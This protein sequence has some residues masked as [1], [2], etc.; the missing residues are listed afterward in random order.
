MPKLK[1]LLI[2][3]ITLLIS[4][5]I[6]SFFKN[7]NKPNPSSPPF[8]QSLIKE[9]KPTATI[10][11]KVII[12]NIAHTPEEKSKG[13]SG[14]ASLSKNEGM[15][16]VFEQE[17]FPSF[18]MKDMLISIDII[19]ILNDS[20]VDI[21]KNIPAPEPES[22]HSNLPLYTPEKPTNYVLEVNAG[23]VDRNN[24]NIGDKVYLS[25]I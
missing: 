24:I 16:F 13:L 18:W 19:W 14:R 12:L 3:I 8:I 25:D 11:E 10:N 6:L 4:V 5:L 2:I 20:I 21:H 9:R 17:G 15:L 1:S 7:P 23:F 22:P